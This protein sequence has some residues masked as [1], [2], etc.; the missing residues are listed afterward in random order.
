M[1]SAF[2][3][4]L[5][6]KEGILVLVEQPKGSFMRHLHC[7]RRLEREGI[8]EVCFPFCPYGAPFLRMSR[9][10]SNVAGLP[11]LVRPCLCERR[12]ICI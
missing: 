3:A 4:T 7:F 10:W 12:H 5:C 1:F 6:A 9:W 8:D 2:V 11:R